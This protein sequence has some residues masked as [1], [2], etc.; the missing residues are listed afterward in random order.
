MMEKPSFTSSL[1]ATKVSS[2]FGKRVSLSART[3]NLTKLSP[4]NSCPNKDTL[5]ASSALK[6]PA[7]F[8]KILY[9]FESIKFSKFS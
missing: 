2:S 9:F 1:A 5:I 4:N 3:S 6:Q 8:G 7:V